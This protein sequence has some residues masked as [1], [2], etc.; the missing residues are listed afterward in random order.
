MLKTHSSSAR[1]VLMASAAIALSACA[2]K[3]AATSDT[4]MVATADTGMKAADTAMAASAAPAM[5]DANIFYVLDKANMLDSAGGAMA[6]QKGTNAEVR[7]FGNMMV[8]DHHAMRKEGMDLA[9]KLGITPAA[10]AND[11]SQAEMDKAKSMY[12]GAAKG[13]DFDKSY[14]DYQV[15]DHKQ[16][17]EKATAAMA[18]A[19]NA[20]L[21]NMLQ[22]AAPKVQAHLDKA[23]SIQSK[24]Q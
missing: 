6:A 10:P 23:Q 22:K 16:V 11:D 17:L 14:I 4:A 13:K 5:S 21:K 15:T 19:Q 20:D 12:N 8:R 24:M 7:A 18:A 3:D 2:K 1:L 9:K